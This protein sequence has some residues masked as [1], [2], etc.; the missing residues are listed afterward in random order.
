MMEIMIARKLAVCFWILLISL[1]GIGQIPEPDKSPLDMSYAPHNYSI[2][3]FQ[4]KHNTPVPLARVIYSRPQI[5]GRTLFGNEIKYNEIWR[6]GAN[7]STELELFRSA[8]IAGKVIAKGRY[9]LYCIPNAD[10]WT[11]V[12]SKDNY[13]WGAFSYK[14]AND[15]ERLT[16]PITRVAGGHVEFLTMYFNE[17]NH[18]VILWDDIKVVVPIT[19]SQGK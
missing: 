8:T 4:G 6:L 9:T 5:N 10:K 17:N 7:E 18:L 19:F 14:K 11:I 2:L 3:K 13:T 15:L 1:Y 12:I 16:V